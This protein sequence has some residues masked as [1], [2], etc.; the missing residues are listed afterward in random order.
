MTRYRRTDPDMGRRKFVNWA[1]GASAGVA[2]LSFITI[3]GAAK[4]VN[5]QT[6]DKLPPVE[7][8]LLVYAEGNNTGKEINIAT[9]E[10]QLIKAWAKR[11][12]LVKS[13]EPNY[14][15]AVSKFPQGVLHSLPDPQGAQQGVIVYSAICTHLGCQVN[16]KNINETYLC[17][18][19]SSNF[20]PKA[21]CKVIGGPAPRPLPQL[22]IKIQGNNLVVAGPYTDVPYGV[23]EADYKDGLEE[24]KKA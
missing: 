23:D 6:P 17:P 5:R 24:A 9:L 22:P 2:G 8:D 20:D 18:C 11:G 7:G 10:P 19:H 1:L 16:W 13:G 15:L 14:L 3:V 12:D 4:P 21:G